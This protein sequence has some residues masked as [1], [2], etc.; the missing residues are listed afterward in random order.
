MQFGFVL[1][2]GDARTAAN[3]AREAEQAGWDGFFVWEP[4]W[5]IDA[6]VSLAAAA[7]VTERIRLGTML[8]PLSRM[9]PWK[10][11]S[12]TAT[13]DQLSNGRV[14][15]A[16]GLGALDTGFAEFGEVTDRRMRAELLDEGLD[17]LI[18]LWRGQPFN[19]AGKHYRIKETTFSP[20]PPPVQQ[21]RIPIW[22]VG[23]WPRKKS[24]R[25]VVRYDGLIP[26]AFNEDGSAR[27]ATPDEIREMR[28][29]VEANRTEPG[30]FDIITEGMTPGDDRERAADIV[31]PWADAG[32][33]WW[34][35][36]MWEAPDAESIR[37]RMQQGPPSI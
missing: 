8:T 37:S 17:I 28:A 36:A 33:T 1:P 9:R 23:A 12:E 7:M 32:A 21:P 18:G 4:V 20:P 29:F 15:L 11:A 31:R 30:P 3:F 2:S 35:E 13:L 19:Y 22:V 14:I 10:L 5:G 16:V 27:Q 34:L 26:S 24:M 25:R 6:W